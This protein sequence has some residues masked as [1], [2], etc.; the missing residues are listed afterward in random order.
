MLQNTYNLYNTCSSSAGVAVKPFRVLQEDLPCA[1]GHV[2]MQK[3][4]HLQSHFGGPWAGF[5][6]FAAVANAVV[7]AGSRSG[8]W[9]CNT[10]PFALLDPMLACCAVAM[11]S[12]S[13]ISKMIFTPPPVERLPP[14]ANAPCLP[15][16]HARCIPLAQSLYHRRPHEEDDGSRKAGLLLYIFQIQLIEARLTGR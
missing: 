15:L 4:H 16:H 3:V 13:A 9:D 6:H 14:S 10:C 11:F 5:Q 1:T 2:T 8:E 12:H 7:P